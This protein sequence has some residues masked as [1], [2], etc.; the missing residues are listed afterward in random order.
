MATPSKAAHAAPAKVETD[1]F[2]KLPKAVQEAVATV[3]SP[4]NKREAEGTHLNPRMG[5]LLRAFRAMNGNVAQTKV[6]QGRI[7]DKNLGV[8][9][10]HCQIA[11]LEQGGCKKGADTYTVKLLATAL[12]V[13]EEVIAAINEADLRERHA[14]GDKLAGKVLGIEEPKPEKATPAKEAS[15]APVKDKAP[16]PVDITK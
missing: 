2:A 1:V 5:R 10:T 11:T 9:T 12:G 6:A 13:S 4:Q 8:T 16:A 3:T 15:P 14:R 7:G